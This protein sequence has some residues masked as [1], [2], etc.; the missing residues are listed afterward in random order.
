LHSTGRLADAYAQSLMTRPQFVPDDTLVP[1]AMRDHLIRNF[2]PEAA[3]AGGALLL[4]AAGAP[5]LA[6]VI[7]AHIYSG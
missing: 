1:Q 7:A 2:G 3:K 6:K 4:T 5:D